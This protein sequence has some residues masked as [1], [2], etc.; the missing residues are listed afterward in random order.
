MKPMK[1]KKNNAIL[2]K[3]E[4]MEAFFRTEAEDDAGMAHE[5]NRIIN[6]FYEQEFQTK[7]NV[8]ELSFD[9]NKNK[10]AIDYIK[11]VQYTN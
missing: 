9:I 10:K 6:I 3:Y 5:L 1:L 8:T 11:N 7:K 4:V 2:S